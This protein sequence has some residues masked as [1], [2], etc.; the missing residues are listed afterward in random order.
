[1]LYYKTPE[2]RKLD[3]HYGDIHAK[4]I[5]TLNRIDQVQLGVLQAD[6]SDRDSAYADR[7]AEAARQIEQVLLDAVGAIAELDW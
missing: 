7:I 3:D 6:L 2:T 5:G 4:I 1:M